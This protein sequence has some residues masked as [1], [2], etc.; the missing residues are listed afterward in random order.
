MV[1][2]AD[3]WRTRMDTTTNWA[4]VATAAVISFSLGNASVPHYVVFI[5]PLLTASF[6]MLEARRLTFYHLWQGRVLLLEEGLIRPALSPDP[7]GGHLDLGQALADHLGRT[8]PSMP[9]SKALAR[10]L[11]RVYVYLFGIQLLAWGFKL[12]NQPAPA[13]SLAELVTRAR[14]GVLPGGLV[15]GLV[16]AVFLAALGLALAHGGRD[17]ARDLRE[18]A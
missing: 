10:R 7:A 6:L 5:A 15:V 1:G 4:I 2:R 12:S 11:R 9:L 3:I 13:S 14:V 17:R 16:G 18:A 8:A